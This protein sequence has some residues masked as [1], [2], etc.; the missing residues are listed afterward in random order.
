MDTIVI[1]GGGLA[2]QKCAETLRSRGY[3]GAIRMVRR[4]GA[5][6]RPAAVV[7]EAAVSSASW[8]GSSLR[9]SSWYSDN[10]V[11]LLLGTTATGV[12]GR[13]LETSAGSLR[14]DRLL[15]ATGRRRDGCRSDPS[16]ARSPTRARC[17]NG[18]ARLALAVVG[19]GFVGMEVA[20]SARSL[21]VEVVLIDV[22]PAPLAGLLGPDVSRWLVGLHR[23][24]GVDVVLGEGVAAA[25]RGSL[26]A[27]RR[28][29]DRLRQRGR[30]HRCRARR[31]L[32]DRS[33]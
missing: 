3:E 22:M 19:A 14:F 17:A 18:F 2:A 10:D 24:E 6:V 11:E 4:A 8:P 27:G 29:P 12:V 23:D 9:P 16:C 30:R 31:V 20:A 5:P 25:Q 28:P 15:I 13:Y 1:A 33:S 7:E 32:A 26:R 21:G